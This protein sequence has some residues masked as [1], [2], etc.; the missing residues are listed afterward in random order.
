MVTFPDVQKAILD[1]YN[2]EKR[3]LPWRETTDPYNILVSEMMLQQTQVDRV[4]PKYLAFLKTFPNPTTLAAASTGEVIKAWQGL[5][6]N[7]RALRLQET[8][9]NHHREIQ[10][11]I[12]RP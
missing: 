7:R 9:K 5:G 10:R 11:K 1:W 12:P 2:Q 8:A 4:I 3:T 6:F